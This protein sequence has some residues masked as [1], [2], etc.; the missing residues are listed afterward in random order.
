MY[1]FYWTGS[2]LELKY[3]KESVRNLLIVQS[4]FKKSK[5]GFLWKR[6]VTVA[7]VGLVL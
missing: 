7:G 1:T 6:K 3:Q 4:S 5:G 2:L